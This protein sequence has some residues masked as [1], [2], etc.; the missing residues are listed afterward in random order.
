VA[1]AGWSQ[2]G[3]FITV[4]VVW[5][6]LLLTL[7]IDPDYTSGELLDHLESWRTSGVLYPELSP[8]APS[9][10]LNYPP[11]VLVLTRGLGLLGVSGLLAGRLI[12]A[13]GAVA[14]VVAVAWW[15]KR[16]G[17]RGARLAGTVG[18]MGASFPVLYGL[19][20]FHLE[21]WAAAGTVAGFALLDRG[22]S[23]RA[24]V[25]GGIA[26]ALAC[27][28]KQTQVI[29]AVVALA[30][31]VSRKRSMA[32]TAVAA[33][34]ATGVV[35]AGVIT[36]V[37]GLEAWRHMLTYTVG[38]FSLGNLGV[39]AVSHIAPWAIL[40]AFLLRTAKT[41]GALTAGTGYPARGVSQPSTKEHGTL[42]D[43]VFWYWCGA[44]LW[45]LSA[46]RVGSSYAYF[47]DLHLATVMWV[48]PR[49]F[50]PVG[51]G[52]A[53]LWR[54][55]L[56]VQVVGAN[57]GVAAALAT[58][59]VRLREGQ[60]DLPGVCA[61]LEGQGDVLAE[62][63]GLVRACGHASVI[64]PFILSSLAS[65][66]LWDLAPLESDL[67]DGVYPLAL[68]PFDPREP[69]AGVHAERW[70][71]ALLAAFRTAPSVEAIGSER[72]LVRW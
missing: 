38:T 69:A 18:L 13:L 3:W 57:V 4:S 7:P 40:F 36:Q 26:L 12:N 24:V 61:L 30:W 20:G 60:E 21:I 11:L 33:F 34:A 68:L 48:G 15:S 45:S 49:L 35:G 10:V 1:L 42:D 43:I 62:E 25:L 41:P 28:A 65:Q 39:Q 46:A 66:G 16:R 58:N 8:Q 17:V 5:A 19:G 37:W 64:H 32:P 44:L 70:H 29:P 23:R 27:F 63:A 6:G 55:L 72:W 54:W 31:V 50:A 56:A 47:L 59:L 9:R 53:V 71:P 51:A 22:G 2:L 52:G 14:L 67:R